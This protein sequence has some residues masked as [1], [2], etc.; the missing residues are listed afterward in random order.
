[1]FSDTVTGAHTSS[2][3]YLGLETAMANGVEPYSWLRRV[4]RDLPAAKAVDDVDALLPRNMKDL[5][6]Q[7]L[8]S[9]LHG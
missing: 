9:E 2:V 5:H 7:D 6:T 4:L 8:I 3:I 1:M